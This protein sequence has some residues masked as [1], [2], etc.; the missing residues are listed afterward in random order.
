MVVRL[1]RVAAVCA[2]AAPRR[3]LRGHPP[4]LARQVALPKKA[5]KRPNEILLEPLIKG[6]GTF[7]ISGGLSAVEVAC[8]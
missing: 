6:N 8:D 2:E 4:E 3:R 7:R 1:G 5:L